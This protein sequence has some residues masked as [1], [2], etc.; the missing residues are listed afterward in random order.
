VTPAGTHRFR[1]RADRL[2]AAFDALRGLPYV[3]GST[4]QGSEVHVLVDR[5][6]D[7]ARV[8]ADLDQIAGN[9]LEVAESSPS[10]EDVFTA[11]ARETAA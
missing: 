4:I 1:V 10:L 7:A 11:L 8:R 5:S 3:R 9:V 6:I 2:M